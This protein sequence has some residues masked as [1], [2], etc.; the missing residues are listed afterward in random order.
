MEVSHFPKRRRNHWML[1]CSKPPPE[2][3]FLFWE[4][5]GIY[6]LFSMDLDVHL[7]TTSWHQRTP[8]LWQ[9]KVITWK[10][11]SRGI[12]EVRKRRTRAFPRADC[13][14]SFAWWVRP[15]SQPGYS[16]GEIYAWT[17]S[18]SHPTH[19]GWENFLRWAMRQMPEI[20]QPIVG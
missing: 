5:R 19:L 11:S 1:V 8:T 13:N 12:A 9:N 4:V 20:P 3:G 15:W 2:R 7:A 10:Y 6:P 16:R 17:F 14:P 18:H